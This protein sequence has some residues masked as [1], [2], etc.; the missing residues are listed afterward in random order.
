[1]EATTMTL[2]TLI[3]SITSVWTMVIGNIGDV[4]TTAVSS[5]V[6]VLFI[7]LAVAGCIVGFG[8]KLLHV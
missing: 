4:L 3:T 5:P 1:M 2:A 6:V 8:K 7:G